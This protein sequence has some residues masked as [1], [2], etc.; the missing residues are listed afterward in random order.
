MSTTTRTSSAPRAGGLLDGRVVDDRGLR[1]RPKRSGALAFA[2]LLI[3]GSAVAGAVLFARA[4]DRIEVVA[5]REAIAKGH[6]VERDDLVATSVSGI[7]G[8]VPIGSAASVVG[9]TAVVDLVPGQVVTR[10][11][12]SRTPM[13]SPGLSS[14][15]LNLDPAR[16]PSS[17]LAPGDVVNVIAVAADAGGGIRAD[18]LDTPAVLAANATVYDVQGAATDGGGVLLTVFVDAD[19]AARIAAYSTAGRVAVVETSPDGD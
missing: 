4:G 16:V 12:V 19:A 5:V 7:D 11:M 1:S 3:A 9:S 13:P 18:E 15:G 6:V 2:A 8:A 10:E 17:G 14:V